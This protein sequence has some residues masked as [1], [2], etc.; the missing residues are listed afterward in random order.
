MEIATHN[1]GPLDRIPLGEGRSYRIGA[2]EVAV[3]R[4]REG[5]VFAVQAA[6]PHRGGP[7]VDGLLGGGKVV[8]PLHGFAFDLATGGPVRN[9]CAALRTYA[10]AVTAEAE[11]LIEVDESAGRKA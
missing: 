9:A 10:V 8:C 2:D 3:F 7:L 1:V 11:V 6:C 5:R 4:T